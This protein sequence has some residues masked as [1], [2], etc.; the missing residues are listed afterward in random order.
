VSTL[1]LHAGLDLV[2]VTV[3]A[4]Q[5]HGIAFACCALLRGA[6]RHGLRPRQRKAE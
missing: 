6:L 4:T 3:L 1:A 5:P 2:D